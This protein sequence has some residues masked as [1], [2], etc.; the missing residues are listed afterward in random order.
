M[1]VFLRIIGDV[2]GIHTN[3][4]NCAGRNYLNLIQ[5]PEHSLQIGD[6]GFDYTV[7]EK[8]DPKHRIILGNHDHYEKCR[9]YPH[10]LGNFGTYNFGPFKFFYIR[11]G[12]SV[13]QWA[14]K[15]RIDWFAEEELNYGES[16]DALEIYSSERPEIVITHECPAEIIP[17]V[18]RNDWGIPPSVTAKLLQA[19]YEVHKP[20]I[21][22]FGHFH[23][24]WV[25]NY[26]GV[27]V[28]SQGKTVDNG[29][30][31]LTKFICLDEL[32]FLD[33]NEDGEFSSFNPQ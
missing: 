5:K 1:N 11:G 21:W 2:H 25:L 23:R 16:M 9:N 18:I 30:R 13:D 14:R 32:A 28:T 31:P 19:C 26:A 3:K 22:I 24:N 10:F 6:F 20:K 4:G 12:R 33:V 17:L 8:V 29:P 15:S 27:G 7:L